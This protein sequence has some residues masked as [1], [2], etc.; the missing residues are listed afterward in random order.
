MNTSI[1]TKV[2][3]I[4]LYG[5]ILAIVMI[6][7]SAINFTYYLL[8]SIPAIRPLLSS[9]ITTMTATSIEAAEELGLAA[10]QEEVVLDEGF[11][12][13]LLLSS[14]GGMISA[15]GS[16]VAYGFLFRVSKKLRCCDTPFEDPVI[17][18][19]SVFGWVLFG[20][21]IL[22]TVSSVLTEIVFGGKVFALLYLLPSFSLVFSLIVLFLVRVFRHGAELQKERDETL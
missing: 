8:N 3:R 12:L 6:I 17:R 13:P 15:I 7:A 1:K 19:T 21:S 10:V 18:A 20:V 22:S 2:N 11:F 14:L 16:A 5:M 9:S 4:G